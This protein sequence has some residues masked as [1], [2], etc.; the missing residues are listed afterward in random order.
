MLNTIRVGLGRALK[1]NGQYAEAA[2]IISSVAE[3]LR[4]ANNDHLRLVD[5]LRELGE[6]YQR[7]SNLDLAVASLDEG[8]A[9]FERSDGPAS[10]VHRR[11]LIDRLAAIRF[12]QGDLST[13][14]NLTIEATAGL[15]LDAIDDPTTVA[16]LYNTHGGILW[17]RG[18]LAQ[19]SQ[20]VAQSL[21]LYQRINDAWGMA[22]AYT[23]LGVLNYALGRWSDAVEQFQRSDKLRTEIGYVPE[24]AVNLKNLGMLQMEMGRHEEA[25]QSL[26]TSLTISR[27]IGDDYGIVIASLQLA[28]LTL[29]QQ[30]PRDARAHLEE[31]TRLLPAAGED[32][33]ILIRW[34]T[35]L[36]DAAEGNEVQAIAVIREALKLAVEAGVVEFEIDCRRVLGALESRQQAYEEAERQLQLSCAL[37]R[38]QASTF[39][40]GLACYELGWHTLRRARQQI[41]IDPVGF[42]LAYAYFMRAQ[43]RFTALDARHELQRVQLALQLLE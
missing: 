33:Q 26:E 37:S 15:S 8:L 21:L 36:A 28:D 39:R 25:R 22:T 40:E 27:S 9:L 5:V 13:A 1:L 38:E 29:L 14:Y 43:E 41:P 18:D 10:Q 16:S 24:R 7:D 20:S 35:G 4:H 17:Q 34:L 32:E 19:A 12:R 23:N 31:A 11:A 3:A 6:T 30:R 42:E 2:Q